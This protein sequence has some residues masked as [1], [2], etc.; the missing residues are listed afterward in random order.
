MCLTDCT[1]EETMKE[2]KAYRTVLAD[3]LSAKDER[4]WKQKEVAIY[5]GLDPRTVKSRYGVGRE[6]IEVHLLARRV[7]ENG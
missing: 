7:S 5:F 6:G 2:A 4:I 1:K 3:L